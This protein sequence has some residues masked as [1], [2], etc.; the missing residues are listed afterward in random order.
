MSKGPFS[1]ISTQMDSISGCFYKLS[2]YA[3][4]I[5]HNDTKPSQVS[6]ILILITLLASSA[7]RILI[8]YFLLSLENR[9]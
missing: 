2:I 7:D 9:G 4:N 5:Y 3:N 1:H 6:V 8:L